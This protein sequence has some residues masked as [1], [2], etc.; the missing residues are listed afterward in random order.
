M[1][2]IIQDKGLQKE[3]YA[4]HNIPTAPFML[5]NDLSEWKTALSGL[6]GSKI[7]AKTRT[8]GYDGR[9]VAILEKDS[10]EK[11]ENIPFRTP[12]VLEEFISAQKEL[13][14][15]VAKDLEGNIVSYPAVE[16]E[17]DPKANLVTFLLCPANLPQELEEKAEEVAK[18][19]IS[20]FEGPGLFAVEMFLDAHENIL[21][22]EIA[23][24]P[25]NS[26]HHSI[27]ACYTS[28]FEQFARILLGLPLGSTQLLNAAVMI[29]ILGPSGF[30]GPFDFR[31][32]EEISAIEG[33]YV[34]LY[35]KR[36]SKP[37][38][39]MGHI[40]VLADSPQSAHEKALQV[41]SLINLVPET[42]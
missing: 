8:E 21:V 40:T 4:A 20:H 33:V 35:G 24:R 17:F 18:Q 1:L 39:K 15:I 9:G 5:V 11:E 22:N 31:G 25:H 37:F 12:C 41:R 23:P 6:K 26:G 32:I 3:F 42:R 10:L 14:V 7:V 30:S 2:R 29:N 36:E 13:S 16:M 28:Q 19:A 27:E 38:R 34:H